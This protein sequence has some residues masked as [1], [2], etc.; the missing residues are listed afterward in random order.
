MGLAMV[1]EDRK[2]HG[3]VPDLDVGQNMTLAVLADFA[4]ATRIDGEAELTAIRGE[5]AQLELKT[6]SP[7][8]PI[9]SLSGGNQQKAVLAKMLLTAPKC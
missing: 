9:T 3:I 7:F 6:A 4:R 5:I 8:L 1:P 2:H